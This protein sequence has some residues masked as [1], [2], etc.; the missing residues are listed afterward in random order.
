MQN[1]TG[2]E[3][4]SEK[5]QPEILQDRIKKHS[6]HG[7]RGFKSSSHLILE[8]LLEKIQPVFL[9]L[10]PIHHILS[11]QGPSCPGD[12]QGTSREILSI[13]CI[14]MTSC[15]VLVFTSTQTNQWSHKGQVTAVW[16]LSCVLCRIYV[17]S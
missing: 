17:H 16:L 9:P 5:P 15:N 4:S 3:Q 13:K 6:P 11:L 12:V 2:Q 7:S 10:S 14:S 1:P 8:N